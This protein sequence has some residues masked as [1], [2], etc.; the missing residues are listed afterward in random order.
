LAR[1]RRGGIEMMVPTTALN[2]GD[3]AIVDAGTTLPADGVV[4]EGTAAV[5]ERSITGEADVTEK[6]TGQPVYAGAR[7]VTGRLVVEITRREQDAVATEIR[8]RLIENAHV[9]PVNAAAAA[10]LA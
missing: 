4:L 9:E 8:G 10:A 5:D 2:A 1:I 7:V 3:I 6:T